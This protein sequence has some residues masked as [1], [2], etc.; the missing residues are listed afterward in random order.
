MA[1]TLTGVDIGGEIGAKPIQFNANS[2]IYDDI[3]IVKM[4][5]GDKDMNIIQWAFML[6]CMIVSRIFKFLYVTV[7]FYFTPIVVMLMVEYSSYQQSL[8]YAGVNWITL[9]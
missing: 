5:Y 8:S 7:Y 1:K 2:K 4:W 9:D 6:M 3:T